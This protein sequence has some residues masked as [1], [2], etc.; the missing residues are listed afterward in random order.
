M[1]DDGEDDPQPPVWLRALQAIQGLVAMV[2]PAV[3]RP[4]WTAFIRW[5]IIWLM[6]VILLIMVV[7][8]IYILRVPPSEIPWLTWL[9]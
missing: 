9:G 3:Y 2:M 7:A 1:L 5:V 4:D 8:L 6:V